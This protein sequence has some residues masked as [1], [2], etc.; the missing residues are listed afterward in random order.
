MSDADVIVIGGGHNGLACAAYLARAGLAVRVL[1]RRAVVGGAAASEE[2]V[3]G[4]H[5]DV[6][7]SVGTDIAALAAELDLARFDLR[8]VDL[9]PVFVA[10]Q[11]DGG[12]LTIYRD[13][14]RTC[15]AIAALSPPDADRYRAFIAA[16][17]PLV[18]WMR[19]A[20]AAPPSPLALAR[21]LLRARLSPSLLAMLA[22]S[23]EG[24]LEETF[25]SPALQGAVAAM[26]AQVGLPL[27][28][29]GS[30]LFALTHA[31]YHLGRHQRPLGGMGE[32]P[33]ALAACV[34]AHGGEVR[35]GAEVAKILLRDG[36]A[37]G[38]QLE[39]GEVL[40][41]RRAV[42]AATH[43]LAT[44]ELL[45]D[46]GFTRRVRRL[47]LGNGL[48]MAVRL[49]TTG[50]PR[51][52]ALPDGGAAAHRAVQ[53]LC[54][55]LDTLRRARRAYDAGEPAAEPALLV[56]TFSAIDPSL[57]P[58]GRH[59][60][61]LW[62]FY[63]P[64]RLA[65]GEHDARAN[66]AAAD[67]M[68]GVLERHAPGFAVSVLARHVQSPLD[69]ERVLSL[70]HANLSHI[71]L[72][73]GQLFFLRP[74]LGRGRYHGPCPRLYLTGASTHPGGGIMG[75]AGRNAARVILAEA[76]APSLPLWLQK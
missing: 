9:D 61:S 8:L 21:G 51:Y 68:I 55:D 73:P 49:A 67:R 25:V 70:P 39:T 14:E 28:R 11:R 1:E 2:L 65:R 5:M 19:E 50:L 42:V 74:L 17:H 22:R 62:G 56:N 36:A 58:E 18:A 40:G 31:L 26:A 3:P 16:A 47:A 52:A 53:I 10:P 66:A 64:Y 33:R 30:A 48:G 29:P 7:G 45:G 34:S 43:I 4:Y 75:L 27:D 69:L 20:M 37:V 38:V 6:G 24:L 59:V 23:C 35:T 12:A 60:V 13:V 63:H 57:A 54:P 76:G 71:D 41:A 32:L 44:A 46:A 15:Q 72:R